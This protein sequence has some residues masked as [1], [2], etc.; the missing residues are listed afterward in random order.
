MFFKHKHIF[1][2][3]ETFLAC[4]C[5]YKGRALTGCLCSTFFFF[6]AFL[7]LQQQVIYHSMAR[8]RSLVLN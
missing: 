1:F 6:M 3:I 2:K 7:T 8:F 4:Y 5:F